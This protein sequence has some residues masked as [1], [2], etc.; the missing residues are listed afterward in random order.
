MELAQP[1]EQCKLPQ[2]WEAAPTWERRKLELVRDRRR[3]V[4]R[5]LPT[6]AADS[7]ITD[8]GL[9]ARKLARVLGTAAV[10]RAATAEVDVDSP[11]LCA[12]WLSRLPLAVAPDG[13]E[14]LDTLM[15]VALSPDERRK[16]GEK[17][18]VSRYYQRVRSQQSPSI[19]SETAAD[20][21]IQHWP[22]MYALSM[23]VADTR[24]RTVCPKAESAARDGASA[25]DVNL[26]LTESRAARQLATLVLGDS[27]GHT[28]ELEQPDPGSHHSDMDVCRVHGAELRGLSALLDQSQR[29]RAAC[30]A[31]L[32]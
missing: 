9:V 15:Q 10:A 13:A 12:R 31:F 3:E 8:D 23:P 30:A 18:T 22:D 26:I 28:Q 21:A 5:A 27:P 20:D 29:L 1:W 25:L 7:S 32:A 19:S 6:A 2:P 16:M 14:S 4:N 24:M 17:V 11:V